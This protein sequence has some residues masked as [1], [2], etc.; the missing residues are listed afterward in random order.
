MIDLGTM[1]RRFG[2]GQISNIALYLDDDFDPEET[3]DLVRSRFP[4][5]PLSVR[6][7]SRLRTEVLRIFDQ[8]FAITRILQVMSLIVAATGIALA[9]IVLARERLSELALY[10]ALGATRRQI[11][12]IFLGKGMAI[13]VLALLMG[14][15]G[16][17]ILACILIYV[18]NRAYFGWTI[19]FHWPLPELAQQAVT[20]LLAAVAASLYPALRASQTPA[21]ELSRDD[22]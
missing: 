11:F 8:T 7:N 21:T 10:R 9:L 4:E 15:A 14:A 16:G 3:V 20:I 13:G 22:L 1:E 18:V 2:A 6:S 17:L 12:R 5:A 19:Q